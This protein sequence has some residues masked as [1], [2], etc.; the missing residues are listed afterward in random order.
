P[1]RPI[2][3]IEHLLSPGSIGIIGVSRHRNFGHII[4]NNLIRAGYDKQRIYIVKE[5]IEALEGC[6]C[7]PSIADLPEKVELFVIALKAEYTPQIVEELISSDKAEAVIL[8]SSGLG[9]R[10]GTQPLE[11]K[12]TAAIQSSRREG[13]DIPVFN[14]GNSMG[15]RSQPG[16][17]D[18]FFVPE[19]KLPLT[20]GIRNNVVYLG[21]SGAFIVTLLSRL[22]AI[23]P[24]YAISIGNQI[25]LTLGDYLQFFK[26]RNEG[27]SVLAAY[28]EGFKELDGLEFARSAR[29]LVKRGKDVVVYK[30]GRTKEGIDATS[31]HTASLAGDYRLAFSILSQAGVLMAESFDDFRDYI[32]LGSFFAGKS[33]GGRRLG[34]LSNAGFETVG[35]AD[36]IQDSRYSLVLPSFSPETEKRL[37]EYLKPKKILDIANIR[38]PLD[39]TPMADDETFYQCAEAILQDE[40]IDCAMISLIPL[41]PDLQTLDKGSSSDEDIRSPD[42]IGQRLIALSKSCEKPFIVCVDAGSLYDPLVNMLEEAGIPTFRSADRAIQVLGCYINYKL[43]TAGL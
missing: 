11:Q 2:H 9:E 36:N 26:D 35:M 37:R 8:I 34:C 40:G 17:V 28:V 16:R 13:R 42:S 20:Q 12:I 31:G 43:R 4:L 18:T 22:T 5:G 14:G 3:K 33:I 6:R 29:E 30:A 10:S 25:D 24:L 23:K 21:Q 32:R 38:N 15:I 39:L 19:E 27:F 41:A 7:F 1:E